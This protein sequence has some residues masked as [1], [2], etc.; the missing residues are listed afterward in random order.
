MDESAVNGL[1][2]IGMIFTAYLFPTL[3][4]LGRGKKNSAAIGVLNVFLGWTFLG[5]VVAL[6]WAFTF[7]TKGGAEP[8]AT[9]DR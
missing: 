7:E 9:L 8:P 4:A 2:M 1:V 3:V 5:W 6:V